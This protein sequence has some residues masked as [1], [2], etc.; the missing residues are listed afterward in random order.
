[1]T[2]TSRQ[3]E[4]RCDHVEGVLTMH[5]S[6]LSLSEYYVSSPDGQNFYVSG[7]NAERVCADLRKEFGLA[8]G[9]HGVQVHALDAER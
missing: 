1:M 3:I 8:I 2:F 6:K 9:D 7:P 5:P 4:M